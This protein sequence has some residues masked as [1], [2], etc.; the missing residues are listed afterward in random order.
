MRVLHQALA[1]HSSQH[2]RLCLQVAAAVRHDDVQFYQTLAQEQSDVAA[3]EG[4]NGL[5]RKIRHL[6]PKGVAKK[7]ANIRCRG[8]QVDD[9]TNH[10][11]QLEAGQE[12]AYTALLKQCAQQQHAAQADLPLMVSLHEIPTRVEVEQ[13]C[14][15]A[16][17]GKAPG[18]DGIQAEQLQ[19]MMVWHSDIFYHLLFKIWLVSAEPIQFKGGYICSIAKKHGA[20][21]AAAMR[22]IMLL[23][24]LAKLH[25]ALLRRKLL[26]WATTNKLV[27]QFGGFKGQQT[28]FASL[29]LRSYVRVVEAKKLS[30]AIIFVDVRMPFTVFFASMHLEQCSICQMFFVRYWQMR[31]LMLQV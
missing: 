10:Y 1:L 14:K 28:V 24:V 19:Q 16:K 22:G 6:L 21:T 31:A 8:P 29:Y 17:K 9:L 12:I 25:H 15:L 3:D 30:L 13:V 7:R 2:R 26:P 4:I 27:T 5:W 11:S 20:S 18:L 23:D